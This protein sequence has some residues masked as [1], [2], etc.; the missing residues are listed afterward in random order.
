MALTQESRE[1]TLIYKG[2]EIKYI[3]GSNWAYM[4]SEVF[5]SVSGAKQAITIRRNKRARH[6]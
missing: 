5:K 4:G 3:V 2:V 1:K 6:K